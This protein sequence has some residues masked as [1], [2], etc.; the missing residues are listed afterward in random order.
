MAIFIPV[1]DNDDAI[2]KQCFNSITLTQK[3]DLRMA[4]VYAGGRQA[5]LTSPR[6]FM[7]FTP[8]S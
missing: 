5:A 7:V 1:F 4:V 6:R 3:E 8:C 2:R